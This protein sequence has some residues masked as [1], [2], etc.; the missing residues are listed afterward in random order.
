MKMKSSVYDVLKWIVIVVS[1]AVCTLIVT[2]NSLWGWDLPVEAI[3]GTISAVT[4]FVGVL[5]GIS[6]INYNREANG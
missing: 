3:T 1:P 2:L 5:I 6:S 4:A